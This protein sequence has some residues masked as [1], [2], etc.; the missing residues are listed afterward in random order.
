MSYFIFLIYYIITTAILF[1]I[2]F[3]TYKLYIVRKVKKTSDFYEQELQ[4]YWDKL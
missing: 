3:G 1:L 4:K 2:C